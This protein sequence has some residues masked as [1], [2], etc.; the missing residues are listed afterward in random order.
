MASQQLCEL[1]G[2]HANYHVSWKISCPAC[3]HCAPGAVWVAQLGYSCC[4]PGPRAAA[5]CREVAFCGSDGTALPCGIQWEEQETSTVLVTLSS[6]GRAVLWHFIHPL[7][8]ELRSWFACTELKKN[9]F[10]NPNHRQKNQI[11]NTY[12]NKILYCRNISFCGEGRILAW[13]VLVIVII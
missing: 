12:W 9:L 8:M 11:Q 7:P 13:S 5:H 4:A 1:E 2:R 6:T 3:A 10:L